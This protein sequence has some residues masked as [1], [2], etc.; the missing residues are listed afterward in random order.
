MVRRTALLLL[1]V[2]VATMFV[3]FMLAATGGFFVP[4]IVDLYVVAQYARAMAEGHPF[5]YNPGEAPS[6]GSTSLLHTA[7]LAAAHAAGARGEGLVAFAILLGGAL[8]VVSVGLARRIGACLGNEEE[9]LL[10]GA[11]V[12]LGGPVVWGFLYGSDIALFMLLCLWL[13]DRL[14]REWTQPRP[15]GIALVGTLLALARPEGLAIALVLGAAASQR[16]SGRQ[17]VRWLLLWLPALSGLA[18]LGMYRWL[19]GHWLGTSVA[20]KSLLGNYG[21]ADSLALLAGFGQDVLRGLLLGLYPSQVPVGF[22]R[23]WAPYFFPPL[24]LVA[25]VAA[26]LRPPAALAA[27]LRVWALVVGVLF[28]LVSPNVFM[29]VHFNRY[30]M[31]A[32]PT[33]HVLLAVG[34]GVCCRLVARD[35]VALGRVLFRTGAAAALVFGLLS[36]VRFGA[37]YGEMA[38]AVYR[39]DVAAARWI[40]E[41]LPKGVAM[42]NIATSVEYL[43][44]HRNLN[45]HGVTSPAFFGNRKAEREAGV[46]ESL[47]RLPAAERPQF[48]ITSERTQEAFPSMRELV[49]G[50]PLFRTSSLS[51]EILIHRMRY[52]L[53]DKSRR[54]FEAE[55]LAAISG[56]DEVDRL[57]VCD[58]RSEAEHGYRFRSSLGGLRLHGT[59]RIAAYASGGSAAGEVVIDA[60]RAILGGESFTVATTPGRD[61][62]VVQRTAPWVEAGVLQASGSRRS[63]VEL[64]EARVVFHAGSEVLTSVR[65]RPRAGW[66]E[67]VFRLP[68]DQLRTQATHLRLTGRYASFHYWFFQ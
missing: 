51:D 23:G 3:G 52:D 27:P 4:Q 66:H 61:L 28:V 49:E 15:W 14:L 47:T 50:P 46:F 24:G 36:T 10:A 60:G 65:F 1:A 48:L 32:F 6:T 17:L 29:G 9:S 21:L 8:F 33:F 20:D 26:L 56:L 43:T 16:R 58:S 31:W 18:L 30:L 37:L 13:L 38:G 34:L 67:Q 63:R 62:V 44:G 12:A 35:D 19:T 22:A 59:V 54:I 64:P 41:H 68:G 57:N 55:T 5:E 45:L 7:I 2:A 39:R 40:S 42:A 11:L 53:V 25:V